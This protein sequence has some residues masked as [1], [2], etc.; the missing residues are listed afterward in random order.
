MPIF[1]AYPTI[2][3]DIAT[4]R[5]GDRSTDVS[6]V[7]PTKLMTELI[8]LCNGRRTLDSIIDSLKGSWDEQSLRGLLDDLQSTSVLIDAAGY[9]DISWGIAANPIGSPLVLDDA[10][11]ARMV[12]RAWLR[13]SH[14]KMRLPLQ[15]R[16][17]ELGSLIASRRSVRLLGRGVF[18]QS[19]L[20]IL[21]CAYG[22]VETS[23]RTIPSAGALYPLSIHVALLS[24]TGI[25]KP[26]IYRVS[27]G[28]DRSLGLSPVSADLNRF[29][30]AFIDPFAV[31]DAHGVI[32][33]S[34][35]L[36]QTGQKYGTRS[37]L[38]VPLEAGHAAQNLLLAATSLGVATLEVGGF[39]E[40][41]L[42]DALCLEQGYR[43]F[44]TVAFGTESQ[45]GT[46]IANDKAE[47]RFDHPAPHAYTPG[48]ALASARIVGRQSWS[49]GR[50]PD[51]RMAAV[52]AVSEAIEWAS[53]GYVHDSRI[54]SY[55]E[56]SQGEAV[57]DP[58]SVIAFHPSQYRL[59]GFP[60]KP[61]DQK[62]RCEWTKAREVTGA[63][64]ANILGDLIY[65]PY[66]PHNGSY[67]TYANSSG[68]AAH[69]DKA[70]AIETSLLE[71]IERDSFMIAYLTRAPFPTID[72]RTLPG[73]IRARVNALA[74]S[75]FRIWVKDHTLEFAPV[76][77][78]VAQNDD[79]PCTICAACSHFD[80][81]RAI[82]HAL[83]EVEACVVAR[84]HNGP[85]KPI[86][87][88]E[89]VDPLDHER[90]YD[91]RRYFQKAD[92]LIDS[93]HPVVALGKARIASVR[94]SK[95]LAQALRQEG[96]EHYAVDLSLP[97]E[98]GG[99]QGRH[100]V[101][102]FVPGLVPMVFG[103]RLEPG[104]MERI[105]HIG[106]RLLQK[107]ISYADLTKFPHPFG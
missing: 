104:G 50:D 45:G 47:L 93:R 11:K 65:F 28:A 66:R 24:P 106:R 61:F 68:V 8:A 2:D 38:F 5:L 77:T 78:V 17:S 44:T 69:P 13:H 6:V 20:D 99:N 92:F 80:F 40:H 107:E 27:Y 51:P 49:H 16:D 87:P 56:L 97:E 48:F 46:P 79:L 12:R 76:A 72:D 54:A 105:Y 100:V 23:R 9:A 96:Y 41:L 81:I 62:A 37:M 59:R 73:R 60:F 10:S 85:G 32:T 53:C 90:L 36:G 29:K 84:L 94:S 83:T 64:E 4:F 101:R 89:V 14:A 26:G 74:K 52:K 39:K 103:Y 42:R 98:K 82:E 86:K 31:E 58:R 34:G 7:A 30:R 33:V 15:A 57:V 3:R 67:V 1:V 25:Y 95:E 91:S 43:P 75:G 21:W 71:L 18:L 19:I 88:Y 22:Q 63:R 55:D 70:Q 102:S 35:S